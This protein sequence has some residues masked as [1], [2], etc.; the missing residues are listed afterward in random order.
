M[1]ANSYFLIPIFYFVLSACAGLPKT[2]KSDMEIYARKIMEKVEPI[3]QA[4][5]K[6]RIQN[7]ANRGLKPIPLKSPENEILVGLKISKEGEITDLQTIKKS[8]YSFLNEAAR[9]S[10]E[11][12]GPLE[13]PPQSCFK[14]DVCLVKWIFVFN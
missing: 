13:P 3:W 10:F 4:E 14:E 12:A 5:V 8:K 6:Q 11:K 1:T 9:E 2:E 7:L